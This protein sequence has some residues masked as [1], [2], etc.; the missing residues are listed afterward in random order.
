MPRSGPIYT[1]P[2]A[3]FVPN[4]VISSTAVNDDFSDIAGALTDSLARNGAGGMTAVLPLANAGFSYLSDPNTGMSR[5]A[6]DTQ[7][8]TCGGANIITASPTIVAV[9]GTMDAASVTQNG[10][11]LTMIGEIRL[12]SGTAAPAGWL[13]CNGSTKARATYPLLWNFAAVEIALANLL[14]TNGNGSTT[15]TIPDLRGRVPAHV[16]GGAGRLN[17]VTMTPNGNTLGATGG[18]QTAALTQANL[19]SGITLATTVTGTHTHTLS[20]LGVVAVQNGTGASQGNLLTTSGGVSTPLTTGNNNS[21]IT[22]S[23]ALGGSGADVNT[24]Q[25]TILLNY[26]IY[27]GA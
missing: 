26:I 17:T 8:I 19:P 23:T 12:W 16:D 21:A 18:A 27:A 13:L 25:P 6:A 1:L 15:F 9:A 14:F 10:S 11:P 4:T 24:T 20:G 7:V 2:E 3:A 22:A 5:S